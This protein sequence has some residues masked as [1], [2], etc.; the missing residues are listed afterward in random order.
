MMGTQKW[1]EEII[2]LKNIIEKTGLTETTKW[3][4]SVYIHKAKNVLSLGAFKHH[5]ALIFFN[6]V[7]IDDI[8]SVFSADTAAKAMRQ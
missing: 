5:F 8:Y 2:L 4:T 7:F 6:G 3:G 1:E